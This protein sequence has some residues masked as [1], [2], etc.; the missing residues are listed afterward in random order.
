MKI[1]QQKKIL[2]FQM[3]ITEFYFKPDNKAQRGNFLS[4]PIRPKV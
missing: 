2:Y 3:S 1:I 4:C